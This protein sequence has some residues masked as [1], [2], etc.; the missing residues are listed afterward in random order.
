MPVR[1]KRFKAS[2]MQRRR[3]DASAH[4]DTIV[5]AE[6]QQHGDKPFLVRRRHPGPAT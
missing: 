6:L 1:A 3:T 5:I 2:L 4:D